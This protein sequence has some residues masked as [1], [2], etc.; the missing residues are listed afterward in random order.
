MLL[1]VI[2]SVLESH[3]LFTNP[4]IPTEEGIANLLH[5]EK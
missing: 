2:V 3:T 4:S 5:G 1:C